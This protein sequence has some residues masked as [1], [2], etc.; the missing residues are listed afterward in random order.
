[1]MVHLDA[2]AFF[3]SLKLIDQLLN[4]PK[5]RLVEISKRA[6]A[7]ALTISSSELRNRAGKEFEYHGA[8]KVTA[9]RILI[10]V[11][12]FDEKTQTRILQKQG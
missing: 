4:R 7:E 1:M 9:K 2:D 10:N 8:P 5:P 6:L 3:A 11:N 12:Q